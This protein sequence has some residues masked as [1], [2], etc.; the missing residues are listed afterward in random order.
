MDPGGEPGVLQVDVDH[1]TEQDPMRFDRALMPEGVVL[2][3]APALG[4]VPVIACEVG[5]RRARVTIVLPSGDEQ[6]EMGLLALA[7]ER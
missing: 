1:I 3:G 7:V 4:V 6:V 2:L 5:G